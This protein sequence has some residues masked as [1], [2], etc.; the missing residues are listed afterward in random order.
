MRDD[1]SAF[2]ENVY[3]PSVGKP[4][5]DVPCEFPSEN[6]YTNFTPNEKRTIVGQ[7]QPSVFIDKNRSI[8]GAEG[9][10]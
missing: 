6:F 4:R 3:G 1:G 2:M 7:S 5:D 9:G 10:I 8:V